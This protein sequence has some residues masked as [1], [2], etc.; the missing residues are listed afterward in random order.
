MDSWWNL[1]E[2]HGSRGGQLSLYKI[3]CPFCTESGNFSTE[4][5]AEKK[6]PNGSKILNFDTLKCGSCSSFVQVIWSGS[7]ELHDFRVQPWPLKYEKA[8]DHLPEDVG[9]YWL[10]AKKSLVDK[11]YDAAAVMTRSAI[12]LALRSHDAKGAN[13]KREIDDLADKRLLPPLMQEWAHSLRDLANDSAHPAPNQ[14]P[15]SSRD[16][17]DIVKFMDFLF[18]YLYQ[19]PKRID[20]FRVRKN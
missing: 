15:T 10:Q 4:F 14:A 9:R 17:S 2:W 8:P 6:Q 16:A 1:G 18:E 7:R 13:L 3:T 20:E 5:H 19:L 11:N 12:Q